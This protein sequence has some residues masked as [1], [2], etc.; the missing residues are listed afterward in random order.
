MPNEGGAPVT[1][2]FK[3]AFDA[4]DK[5]EVFRLWEEIFATQQWTDGKFTR[6]FEE[7]WGR[8]NGIGAA[9]TS[10]WSGAAIAALEYFGVRGKTVLCPTNTFIGTA[11][12]VLK[13]GG[14]VVFGD[15]RR[16]DLCLSFDAVVEAAARHDLAAVWLVHIGGHMAFDAPRIA[17]FCRAKG[18]VLLEDCAHAHGAEWHGRKPGG[19]GDAGVYSFFATKSVALGEGGL[20]VSRHPGLIEFAR[21]YRSYGQPEKVIQGSNHRMTEFTAALGCV[22]VDRMG[23]ILA[24]K[25]EFARR[26]LDPKY[27][28]RVR[29][30]EGMLSGYYK[31][32]VFEPV[33]A[34]T[35]KVYA[36]LCHR[37]LKREGSFPN[38]EWAANNHW[39]VPLYYNP[40]AGPG[41]EREDVLEEAAINQP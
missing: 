35:S 20:V 4:R 10:S 17:E 37:T 39:C 25:R 7:K 26:E 38:A 23:E 29:F 19:W 13:A 1:G 36:D 24:W 33:A 18:I 6:L 34:S 30:P 11:L 22:Q 32:I 2:A 9:A 41:V 12:A 14:E 16:D 31:Y 8:W 21:K 15:C 27:A 28:K 3:I 5:R 40:A